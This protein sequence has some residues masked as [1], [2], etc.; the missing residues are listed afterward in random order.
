MANSGNKKRKFKV[1]RRLGIELPGMGRP[2]ALSKRKYPPGHHGPKSRQ[3]TSEFGKRLAE[4]QK[5]RFHYMMREGQIKLFVKR[6]KKGTRLNWVEDFFTLLESRLDNIVFRLGFAPSILAAR[7]MIVHK[8]VLV[9]GQRVTI[10]SYVVRVGSTVQLV[11]AYYA[12]AIVQQ[13]R[14][15]PRLELP[16]YL[17]LTESEKPVGTV[18]SKP[19]YEDIPFVLDKRFIAE[20]YNK[21]K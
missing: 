2:G 9:N 6:S 7:Q 3:S 20:Y 14:Q 5:L 19:T 17:T 12:N 18:A 8:K 21:T 15:S 16:D 13:T 10:P 1:Q 4:K 11:E